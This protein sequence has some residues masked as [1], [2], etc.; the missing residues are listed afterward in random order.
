MILDETLKSSNIPIEI[1]T[2]SNSFF[3]QQKKRFSGINVEHK[4]ND[5]FILGGSLM[6]LSERS[7]S[8]KANYG[9]EPVNNTMIG[10][11][12]VFATEVPFLTRLA[13]KLPNVKTRTPSIISLK[14]EVAYLHAGKPKNSGYEDNA[15]VYI[16][17]FEGAETNIDLK[18]T[19]SWNLSSVPQNVKGSEFE[20]DDLRLGYNRAKLSW[21]N[22]DPVFYT[23]QRPSEIDDNEL[24]KNETRRIF[25]DEIFPQQD[26]IEGQSRIQNTFD[27]NYIPNEKGPY[28]NNNNALFVQDLKKNWAGIT[29]KINSTNFEQSNVEFIQFWLLDTFEEN[30]SNDNDLGTLVFNLG[31]NTSEAHSP[32]NVLINVSASGTPV[33]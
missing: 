2:E 19:F 28:N 11:N 6:N 13:N 31:T 8:Q 4:F 10:L 26:L 9:V 12:G 18:D 15:T 22:I 27:L 30:P 5:N 25:I 32:I 17:D 33:F 16:D 29:R 21:Y 3:A 1:S 24:S 20:I 7:I 14:G 23:R